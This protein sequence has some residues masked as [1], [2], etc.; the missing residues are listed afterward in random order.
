MET[1]A[2]ELT[3]RGMR[4]VVRT[5]GATQTVAHDLKCEYCNKPLRPKYQTDYKRE[6]IARRFRNEAAASEFGGT[7]YD[8]P[9]EAGWYS[10]EGWVS[11]LVSRKFAG[12]FGS[13]GDN[14]FCGLS[15]ARRWAIQELKSRDNARR[16]DR[17]TV[18]TKPMPT[19]PKADMR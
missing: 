19:V 11:T 6:R 12:S 16:R 17:Q 18:P 1:T 9:D 14:M 4:V 7:R 2:E 8:G 15:C 13:Y 3:V 5:K 10:A